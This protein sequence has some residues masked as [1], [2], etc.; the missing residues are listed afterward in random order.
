MNHDKKNDKSTV[1]YYTDGACSNGSGAFA[2]IGVKDNEK[3]MTHT[4]FEEATTSN[5][6]ELSA[7]LWVVQNLYLENMTILSDSQYTVNG[8]NIWRFNWKKNNWITSS[9]SEV[10]NQDLW[11]S[12]D[13][14]ATN[15]T[16]FLQWIQ[17]HNN[18]YYNEEVDKLAKNKMIEGRNL[19]TI[20]KKA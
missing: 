6:M 14:I 15:K 5:R 3:F 7:V 20:M 19:S 18:N 13:G 10:L 17:G 4:H 11:K 9:G 1:T 8:F 2:V 12:L 16:F